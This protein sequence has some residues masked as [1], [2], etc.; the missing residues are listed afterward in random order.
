M[1]QVPPDALALYI[2]LRQLMADRKWHAAYLAAEELELV[3]DRH[4]MLLRAAA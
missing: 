1:T 4:E 3:M 2:K